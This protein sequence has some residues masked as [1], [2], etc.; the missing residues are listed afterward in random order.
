MA[1]FD[2]STR[3]YSFPP[4][5]QESFA[6]EG[7]VLGLARVAVS[8]TRQSNGLQRHGK[9]TFL[10]LALSVSRGFGSRFTLVALRVL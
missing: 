7:E 9:A 4:I 1:D 6:G 8:R 3:V 10:P 2:M 5:F